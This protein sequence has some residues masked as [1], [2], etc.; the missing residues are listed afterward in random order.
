MNTVF[1]SHHDEML[2]G[3]RV[4]AVGKIRFSTPRGIDFL[5]A[6]IVRLLEFQGFPHM[7]LHVRKATM[8]AHFPHM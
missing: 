5:E 3:G 1:E 6:T 8:H 7:W 2:G 4:G